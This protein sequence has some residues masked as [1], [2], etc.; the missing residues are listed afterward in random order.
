MW[1]SLVAQNKLAVRDGLDTFEKDLEAHPD[2]DGVVVGDEMR[3]RQI[4]TNLVS[5]ACKFTPAGG[6][7][8]VRTRLISPASSHGSNNERHLTRSNTD[9]SLT[10]VSYPQSADVDLEKGDFLGL[11]AKTLDQHNASHRKRSTLDRIVV[12]IEVSDTGYGIKPKDIAK[13]KLFC[14]SLT[15]QLDPRVAD[16]ILQSC[17]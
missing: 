9:A 10:A 11:S 2:E 7:L 15:L 8:T 6:T 4:V 14:E 13:G 5:N 1:D 3:L 16:A 12:R 17:I